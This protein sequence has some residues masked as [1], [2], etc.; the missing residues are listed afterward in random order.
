MLLTGLLQ[1]C[2]PNAFHGER[3]GV[4]V[5]QDRRADDARIDD[6]DIEAKAVDL[7]YKQSGV[8][9]HV[10]V[11]SFNRKV[12]LS[13]EVP[14]EAARGEVEK[15]V[16]SVEK[17]GGVTNELVV[18]GGSS[19]LSRSN[20]SLITSNVK[21]KLVADGWLDSNM[22]KVF[23][24]NGTVFL[25]GIVYREEAEAAAETASS[26]KGVQRVVKLFEYLN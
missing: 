4:L 23:V 22:V 15:I 24:E 26:T 14:T 16:S 8:F 11:T 5:A 19:L 3:A 18:S 2:F 12:L 13:G 20:D 21:M 1:G 25:M 6:R 7:V 10:N 17:V 9:M